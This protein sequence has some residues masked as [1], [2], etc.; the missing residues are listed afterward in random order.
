MF[1][2]WRISA[3]TS[4]RKQVLDPKNLPA[5][6]LN[7]FLLPKSPRSSHEYE[8]SALTAMHCNTGAVSCV[9]SMGVATT[10]FGV[11][12]IISL[13]PST[14]NP[15]TTIEASILWYPERSLTVTLIDPFKGTLNIMDALAAAG[16]KPR[17]APGCFNIRVIRQE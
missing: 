16:S 13:Q 4:G 11:T 3:A 6:K 12:C 14:L 2:D 15:I 8:V 10:V 5:C 17:K 1:Q 9:I 7:E